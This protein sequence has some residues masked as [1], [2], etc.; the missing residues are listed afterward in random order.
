MADQDN[1]FKLVND[2]LPNKIDLRSSLLAV[3]DQGMRSTC[4]AFALTAAHE[5]VRKVQS[6]VVEDLSEEVLYWR[7][8]QID[9]D[10]ELGTVFSSAYDA[11]KNLG[12]PC[13]DVW[14]YDV[15]RDDTDS[16]YIPPGTLYNAI[17]HKI[18]MRR[19]RATVYNIQYFLARGYTVALGILLS[20][21]FYEPIDGQITM[22]DSEREFMEGHA[23]LIVGYNDGTKPGEGTFILRNSWGAD[24]GDKGYGYL[25]YNYIELYGGETW[26]VGLDRI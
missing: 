6:E 4:L 20:Q 13:E 1:A 24:W 5:V 9:G 26:I 22:P 21:G 16:S 8:K 14:P 17:S 12:Q 3:Q 25:P 10:N 15:N 18:P 23:V 2:N 19:I 11:L 7:C